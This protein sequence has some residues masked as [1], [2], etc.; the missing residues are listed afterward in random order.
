M[1]L[2]FLVLKKLLKKSWLSEK[3][4]GRDSRDTRLGGT[5]AL[6]CVLFRVVTISE[7]SSH[8]PIPVNFHDSRFLFNT[9]HEK[10][11]KPWTF[12]VNTLLKTASNC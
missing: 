11:Q 7:P 12:K 1:F 6:I 3:D 4:G 10:T 2:F 5:E 8:M 9:T